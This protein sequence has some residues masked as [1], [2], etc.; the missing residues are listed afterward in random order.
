MAGTIFVIN[1]PNLNLL[2]AR[3]PETYGRATLKDVQ[4]LCEKTAKRH[5]WKVEFRQSNIEGEMVDFIQEAGRTK[6]KGIVINPAGYTTTSIAIMDALLGVKVPTIE[7]HIS[8]IHARED[9]R[10]HSYVSK[11]ARGVI[12]GMGVNGYALAIDG[13]AELLK[14]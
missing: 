12:C 6:A 10:H 11:A 14:K 13:L 8:N 2:G 5:G 4:K 3:E 1:G 9:F 7:V